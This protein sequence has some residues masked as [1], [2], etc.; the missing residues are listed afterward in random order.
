MDTLDVLKLLG[1]MNVPSFLFITDSI[2]SYQFCDGYLYKC[3][4]AT[5]LF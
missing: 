3:H 2:L 1:R 5:A 4:T